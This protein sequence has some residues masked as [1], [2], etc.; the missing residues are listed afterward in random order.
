[1]RVRAPRLV[2]S[3]WWVA[4][5]AAVLTA[6]VAA[7]MLA[8][9]LEHRASRDAAGEFDLSRA[10]APPEV[11]VRAM[12]RDGVH[13]LTEP[14]FM[15]A[16]AVEQ[17]NEAE[18]G[19]LLVG[20]DRV[21]G[22]VEGGDARAYPLR[23]LRWH[24]VVNDVVGGEP[25]AVTYSPLCDSV[26]VYSRRL[27]AGTVELGISG[28]LV[29][30][31]PLLYDRSLPP[32]A[33]PLWAQ[34]DGRPVAGPDPDRTPRLEPRV[35]TLTTWSAW[36]ARHPMT[37]VLAPLEELKRLYKRD[38]YHSY[39]GSELLRFPVAPLPPE[40]GLRLKDRLVLVRVG[41]RDA[42]FSLPQL[43][44]AG[45]GPAGSVEVEVGGVRLQ[46]DYRSD[47]GVAE[48]AVRDGAGELQA[49]RY[50]FW[51]ACYAAG[52]TIPGIISGADRS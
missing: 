52:E 46:I 49:V 51:F 29:N 12:P 38:P 28:L 25:I 41:G 15:A 45:G 43:E 35:A 5:A 7:T 36:W 33:S 2:R 6:A 34:L 31:N 42:A 4:A 11:L 21:V 16:A 24:E 23:L 40:E 3:G 20:D 48:V 22:V 26:A 13:V 18:R 32:T 44:A 17:A 19:K 10:T 47:P 9:V 30:S 39:F 1:M 14:E 8:P 27:G 37:Q 50:G